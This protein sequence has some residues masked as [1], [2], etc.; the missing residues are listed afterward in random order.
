[1]KVHS[2]FRSISGEVNHFG[3]GGIATFIRLG[4]CNLRCKWCDTPLTQDRDSP[5]YKDVGNLA[6]A[7]HVSELS[8]A[9]RTVI[10]TGGEPLLQRNELRDLVYFLMDK[11]MKVCVETNGSLPTFLVNDTSKFAW[12]LDWKPPSSGE[13]G[14]FL[15]ENYYNCTKSSQ[16][17]CVVDTKDDLTTF[18]EWVELI[19]DKFKKKKKKKGSCE[20]TL[21][22]SAT[23]PEML[24]ESYKHIAILLTNNSPQ[25]K[26]RRFF[27]NL[28]IHKILGLA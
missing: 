7:I 18:L 14:S 26:N 15:P 28:Q 6:L 23:S 10:I 21:V 25:V 8:D 17:K 12:S 19:S 22:I 24:T 3:Q 1:M 27:F 9:N 13:H 5:F 16:I 4:G 2:I 11:G 20:P